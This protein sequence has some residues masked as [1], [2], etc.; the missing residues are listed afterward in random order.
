MAKKKYTITFHLNG[1]KIK[2]L[3]D[4]INASIIAVA[5]EEVFTE[6]FI[7]VQKDEHVMDRH[8][9]LIQTRKLFRDEDYRG[10]FI[11]NLLLT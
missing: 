9:N 11:N 6:S 5:P 1:T 10:I 8:L 3:T 4:D 2:K 7:S